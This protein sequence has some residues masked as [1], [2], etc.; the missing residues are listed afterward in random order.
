MESVTNLV[1]HLFNKPVLYKLYCSL[2]LQVKSS[3]EI[4]WKS[5]FRNKRII[6]INEFSEIFQSDVESHICVRCVKDRS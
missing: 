1:K 2:I 5:K 3:N 4:K 6:W